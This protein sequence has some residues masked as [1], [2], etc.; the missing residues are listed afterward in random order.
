M[1]F[2]LVEEGKTYAQVCNILNENNIPTKSYFKAKNNGIK[3]SNNTI[4][5]TGAIYQIISNQVYIGNTVNFK[6]KRKYCGNNKKII[7]YQNDEIII[8]ENTHQPL[9]SK[10]VFLKLNNKNPKI[11]NKKNSNIFA[12]KIKCANCGYSLRNFNI[13][14]NNKNIGKKYYCNTKNEYKNSKCFKD[15]ILEE[16]LIN[17]VF[18]SLKN[19]IFTQEIVLKNNKNQLSPEKYKSQIIKLNIKKRELYEKY[20]E[21]KI[22]K[23]EYIKQKTQIDNEIIKYKNKSKQV[24]VYN[25]KENNTQFEFNQFIVNSFIKCI[26]V[27]NKNTIEIK[28]Y[29]KKFF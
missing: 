27:Y 26:Y 6:R 23:N 8:I 15:Y 21:N 5:K 4:W 19:I 3:P 1:V 16:D 13:Y 10:E 28:F 12:Y 29:F 18:E 25:I 11:N 7:K 2:N 9:I 14:K 20:L 24:Q 17:I 22:N